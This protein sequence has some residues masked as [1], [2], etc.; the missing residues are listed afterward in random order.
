MVQAP[1]YIVILRYNLLIWAYELQ[2]LTDL[3]ITHGFPM[4]LYT[5]CNP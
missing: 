2:I 1:E 5:I 3:Q 4:W